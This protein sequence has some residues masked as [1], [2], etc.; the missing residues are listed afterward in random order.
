MTA[1][2]AGL[3]MWNWRVACSS[4][5]RVLARAAAR[6]EGLRRA[7]STRQKSLKAAAARRV[8]AR[9]IVL[10]FHLC[11]LASYN[12]RIRGSTGMPSPRIASI[13]IRRWSPRRATEQAAT[14]NARRV[15]RQQFRT[16]WTCAS[17]AGHE[18]EAVDPPFYFAAASSSDFFLTA[19]SGLE[20]TTG[21]PEVVSTNNV[22][23]FSCRS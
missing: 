8:A 6:A 10:H 20:S 18:G 1:A 13:G 7:A 4:L 21:A 3:Q 16:H 9:A 2:S 5:T 22:T 15:M 17:H 12:S 11:C 23:H 19:A 14:I